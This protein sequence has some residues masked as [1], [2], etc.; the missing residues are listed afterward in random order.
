[1]D[2]HLTNL[3]FLSFFDSAV[4]RARKSCD[5]PVPTAGSLCEG[6]AQEEFEGRG[7]LAMR[8]DQKS[9]RKLHPNNE[10]QKASWDQRGHCGVTQRD[11]SAQAQV[12]PQPEVLLKSTSPHEHSLAYLT[13][14]F[15]DFVQR[16]P[17]YDVVKRLYVC[18]S[19]TT[20]STTGLSLSSA[21][22]T[23]ARFQIPAL[24]VANLLSRARYIN[25]TM[26]NPVE[27]TGEFLAALAA[28][29]GFS[30]KDAVLVKKAG[31][32]NWHE[33][34]QLAIEL[35]TRIGEMKSF[36]QKCQRRYNDFSLR[37]MKDE[38]RDEI[39]AAVAQF[40]RTAMSQIEVLKK[41]AVADLE[42]QKGASFPAHKLGV[43]VI[44]NE[45]LQVVSRLSEALRGVRIKQ[46]IAE[47]SKVQVQYDPNVARELA[48]EKRNRDARAGEAGD[49]EDDFGVLEQEFARENVS[50]VNELV[51]TRERVREA[52]RTVF[53][54]ANLNHVFATKVLEQAREIEVLY[55]L[56][57]E[58]TNYVDRG[59]RE[60]RK[61]KQR[62]PILQYGLAVFALVLAFALLFL[63]WMKSRR[64]IFFL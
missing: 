24:L 21:L 56:A 53:E 5:L 19:S 59:N 50:L 13:A 38:E 30:S 51:E 39:D 4:M 52:E 41:D 57:V 22:A 48:E 31:D 63:D 47:K 27:R 60:L 58:A 3:G 12:W 62:G 6:K 1:M 34:T 8:I 45:D 29:H 33:F 26:I 28:H 42:R 25:A 44:L 2:R 32:A 49:G 64:S 43:V 40:L 20:V 35:T 10:M 7:L 23:L 18:T 14:C 36:V 54:I 55:E 46:A 16:R 61:M 15:Q 9:N 37:G 11:S 17:G